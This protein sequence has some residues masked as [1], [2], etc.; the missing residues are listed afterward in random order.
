MLGLYRLNDRQAAIYQDFVEML[1]EMDTHDACKIVE[2]SL[3]DSQLQGED[4]TA[5]LMSLYG[6]TEMPMPHYGHM[7]D[8]TDDRGTGE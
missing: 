6:G 3:K 5:D 2:D 1:S 8:D 4:S 7:T